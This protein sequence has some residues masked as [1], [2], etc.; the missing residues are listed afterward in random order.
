MRFRPGKKRLAV[1]AFV[2][3]VLVLAGLAWWDRGREEW[4]I[5]RTIATDAMP[6]QIT[7]DGRR[8]VASGRAA[9]FNREI[10]LQ[11]G[12]VRDIPGANWAFAIGVARDRR[13]ALARI[14]SS[15][16]ASELVWR[17]A[18]TGAVERRLTVSGAR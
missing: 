6:I 8:V 10:D 9:G 15:A 11:S 5:R 18:A 4:P 1:A 3:V 7:P 14:N 17:D 2:L 12:S 16:T 13:H